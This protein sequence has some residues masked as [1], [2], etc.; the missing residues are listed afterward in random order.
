MSKYGKCQ[1][2]RVS[3]FWK[4][5]VVG[6]L[7]VIIQ[8]CRNQNTDILERVAQLS[9]LS[10]MMFFLSLHSC[11]SG[12][13][14]LFPEHRKT[15]RGTLSS[16]YGI[17]DAFYFKCCFRLFATVYFTDFIFWNVYLNFKLDQTFEMACIWQDS[18]CFFHAASELV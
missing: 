17:C 11:C 8:Q 15:E 10:I 14:G 9:A 1:R 3:S 6:P 5:K 12:R 4:R 7:N 18:W 13:G 16:H 2:L